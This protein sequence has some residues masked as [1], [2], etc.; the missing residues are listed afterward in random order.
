MDRIEYS[1]K[2][3]HNE[4]KK[5]KFSRSQLEFLKKFFTEIIKATDKLLEREVVGNVPE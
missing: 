1:C 2:V 3:I 4:L 5:G